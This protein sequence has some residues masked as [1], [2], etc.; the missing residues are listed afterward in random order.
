MK[1]TTI[2]GLQRY[3]DEENKNN[4]QI[5]LD[6]DWFDILYNRLLN[7]NYSD[8]KEDIAS[9]SKR[10][11]LK[12]IDASVSRKDYGAYEENLLYRIYQY[13]Y[14]SLDSKLKRK[15]R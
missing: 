12:V 11:A 13:A 2:K 10:E 7:G 9:M 15:K 4:R 5:G 14:N 1:R 8:V 3:A 6:Y